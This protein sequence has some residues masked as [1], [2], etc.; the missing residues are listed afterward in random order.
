MQNYVCQLINL[1]YFHRFVSKALPILNI[2]IINFKIILHTY[3]HTYI[4]CQFAI[5][6]FV[7]SHMRLSYSLSC[8][9]VFLFPLSCF[10]CLCIPIRVCAFLFVLHNNT[11]YNDV[12]SYTHTNTHTNIQIKEKIQIKTREYIFLLLTSVRLQFDSFIISF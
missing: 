7:V 6:S 11:A 8:I 12:H 4:F 2:I 9:N 3:K 10:V 1:T 5:F